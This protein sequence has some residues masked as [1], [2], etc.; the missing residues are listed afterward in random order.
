MRTALPRDAYL[1]GGAALTHRYAHRSS[2]DLDIFTQVHDPSEIIDD[3]SLQ[4]GVIVTSQ[5]KNTV[6]L[7]VASIPVSVIRYRYQLLAPLE[8]QENIALPLASEIDLACMK[9]AAISQRGYARDFWDLYEILQRSDTNLPELLIAYRQKY[10]SQDI[11]HV[12]RSL[13]Y[14]GDAEQIPL[15]VELSATLW[16]DVTEYFEREVPNLR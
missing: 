4:P 9:M 10:P 12:V 6:Y 11:G 7:E 1:A 3:L 8:T 5:A 15:P 2:L 14:F 13:V 16:R